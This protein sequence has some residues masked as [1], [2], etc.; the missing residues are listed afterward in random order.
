MDTEYIEM[1]K[2]AVE[3]QEQW[4]PKEGDCVG[5]KSNL[6]YDFTSSEDIEDVKNSGM[7]M[8]GDYWLPRQEDLQ[9][10]YLKPYKGGLHVSTM[11]NSFYRWFWE[12]YNNKIKSCLEQYDWNEI[13][14][15]FVMGTLYNKRWNSETKKWELVG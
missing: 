9:Q 4:E 7:W 13:W 3:I 12:E 1:C 11:V 5:N 14:L 6:D 15:C 10:I 8:Y 2:S